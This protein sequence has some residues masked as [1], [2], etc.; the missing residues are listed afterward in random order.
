MRIVNYNL[1]NAKNLSIIQSNKLNGSSTN[2]NPIFAYKFQ[3]DQPIN[4]DKIK[5]NKDE[6]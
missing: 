2:Q 3:K 1:I 4:R 5:I 6:K